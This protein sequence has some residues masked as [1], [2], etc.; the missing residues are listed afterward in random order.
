MFIVFADRIDAADLD[1]IRSFQ[2]AQPRSIGDVGEV[3]ILV[4]KILLPH[5]IEME[6]KS[7]LPRSV[8]IHHQSTGGV[9]LDVRSVVCQRRAGEFIY[10]SNSPYSC[11]PKQNR[12]TFASIFQSGAFTCMFTNLLMSLTI[13]FRGA[14]SAAGTENRY[15]G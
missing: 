10:I 6:V 9:D 14:L 2:E 1:E 11:I 5:V 8:Q 7:W 3:D 13:C 12:P 4:L 15:D